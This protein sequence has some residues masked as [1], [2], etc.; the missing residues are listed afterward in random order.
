MDNGHDQH[1]RQMKWGQHGGG[2]GERL[3]E[4]KSDGMSLQGAHQVQQD[5]KKLVSTIWLTHLVDCV[6]PVCC[7]NGC[8]VE[9][10]E[11][12]DAVSKES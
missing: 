6:K 10:K 8:K 4:K 5:S 2:G 9:I 3:K 1:E 7:P 12:G 11:L